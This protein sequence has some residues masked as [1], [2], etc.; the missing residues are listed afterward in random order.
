[1]FFSIRDCR[2]E[3]C[4]CDDSLTLSLMQTW[5]GLSADERLRRD[6]VAAGRDRQRHLA[7]GLRVQHLNDSLAQ[8][9]TAFKCQSATIHKSYT[10][11]NYC[12][13]TTRR[14]TLGMIYRC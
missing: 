6:S 9:R 2:A 7:N 1:M 8:R 3:C 4:T 14:I 13:F 5:L 11:N 12:I 10:G